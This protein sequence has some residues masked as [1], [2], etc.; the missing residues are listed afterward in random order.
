[1]R[2]NLHLSSGKCQQPAA[3][4]R[5]SAELLQNIIKETDLQKYNLNKL[6]SLKDAQTQNYDPPKDLWCV[7]VQ[8]LHFKCK[9]TKLARAHT[10]VTSREKLGSLHATAC[11]CTASCLLATP[12][13]LTW[14][15]ATS[16]LSHWTPSTFCSLLDLHFAFQLALPPK[17]NKVDMLHHSSSWRES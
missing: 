1:M 7:N 4:P 12:I 3:N 17:K 11:K 14:A 6:A 16:L 9:C 2:E 15:S 5:H 13:V 8:T 10:A